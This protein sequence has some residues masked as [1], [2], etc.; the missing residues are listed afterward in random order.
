MQQAAQKRGITLTSLSRPLTPADLERFD[1][2]IGVALY[3]L[4]PQHCLSGRRS[5]LACHQDWP[6]CMRLRNRQLGNAGMDEDNLLAIR[7]AAEH[8]RL[9][10]L[11]IPRDYDKKASCLHHTP[12][13]MMLRCEAKQFATRYHACR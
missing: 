12:Y 3:L 11:D 5:T 13:G 7:T 8:W 6:C 10:Q 1:H 4:L 9:Y 2:I